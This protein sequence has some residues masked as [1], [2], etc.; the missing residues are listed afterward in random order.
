MKIAEKAIS[1]TDIFTVAELYLLAE[2]FDSNQLFGLPDKKLQKLL[3]P[4]MM[5]VAESKLKEKEIL[6]EESSLTEGGIFI[7]SALK[8]YFMSSDYTRINN[9]MVAFLPNDL[10]K[11]VALIE[12]EPEESYLLKV[13]DK[14]ALLKLLLEE[15][16]LLR[17]EPLEEEKEMA[18]K[19]VRNADRRILEKLELNDNLIT[20]EQFNG[21]F[22]HEEASSDSYHQQWLMYEEEGLLYAV[23]INEPKYYRASQYWFT[24]LIFDSLKIPYGEE[25]KKHHLT[26]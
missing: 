9:I 4:R 8:D 25:V 24:K 22:Y 18:L 10:K 23:D 20:I 1:N 3:N 11:V 21:E 19:K 2:A 5:E 14:L 12:I 13:F 15:L 7:I 17:R 26:D 16:S 6:S